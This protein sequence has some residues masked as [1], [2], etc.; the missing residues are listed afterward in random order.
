VPE[1]V[2]NKYAHTTLALPHRRAASKNTGMESSQEFLRTGSST[3][4]LSLVWTLLD[5]MRVFTRYKLVC[6]CL[7]DA[8]LADEESLEFIGHMVSARIRMVVIIA[9]RPENASE[10]RKRVL[11]SSNSDGK[12]YPQPLFNATLL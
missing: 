10:L 11:H 12:F 2:P 4:S 7:D 8:H 3:K 1:Q 6:L 9:H 5:I